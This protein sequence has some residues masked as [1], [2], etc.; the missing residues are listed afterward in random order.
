MLCCTRLSGTRFMA[1][2]P[3]THLSASAKLLLRGLLGRL[4]PGSPSEHRTCD[5]L[6][7]ESVDNPIRFK[8]LPPQKRKLRPAQG[9]CQRWLGAIGGPR[10]HDKLFSRHGTLCFRGPRGTSDLSLTMCT[11]SPIFAR[12]WP[13]KYQV[14][15]D[16][17]HPG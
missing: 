16:F 2:W 3:F 12:N 8:D 4:H 1:L 9:R 5:H 11:F 10:Q 17:C 6:E 7:Y 13:C 15:N 14:T